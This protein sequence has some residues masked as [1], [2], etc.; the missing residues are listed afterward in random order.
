IV[1]LLPEPAPAIT[2]S[3]PSGAEITAACSGV[4][5][6]TPSRRASCAGLYF[7]TTAFQQTPLTFRSARAQK[8]GYSWLSGDHDISIPK[9]FLMIISR[10][11][12][13]HGLG[14]T[15]RGAGG[16]AQYCGQPAVRCGRPVGSADDDLS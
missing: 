11:E 9:A 16:A 7:V 10:G 13:R 6:G 5:S 1:S 15:G 12:C 3:G 8:A 14:S 4:G 2:A